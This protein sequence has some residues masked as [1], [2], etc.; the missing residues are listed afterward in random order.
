MTEWRNV[1]V[2][3]NNIPL[4]IADCGITQCITLMPPHNA[5]D[6]EV[7]IFSHSLLQS[8]VTVQPMA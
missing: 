2:E 3:T 6:I 1:D 4:V 5:S 8:K 7:M